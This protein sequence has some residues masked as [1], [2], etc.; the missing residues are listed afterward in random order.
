MRKNYISTITNTSTRKNHTNKH[1]KR[2]KNY[3][4]KRP[5]N[6]KLQ[7]NVP[8]GTYERKIEALNQE[9]MQ[10][11]IT[12]TENKTLDETMFE[13]FNMTSTDYLSWGIRAIT[14]SKALMGTYPTGALQRCPVTHQ[15]VFLNDAEM[16]SGVKPQI[17]AALASITSKTGGILTYSEKT[18]DVTRGMTSRYVPNE[19]MPP[20]AGGAAAWTEYS[21]TLTIIYFNKSILEPSEYQLAAVSEFGVR[22]TNILIYREI[23]R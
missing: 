21:D 14:F 3:K 4:R 23:Q 2:T 7:L 11:I 16:P 15:E 20:A 17:L 13:N 12:I 8:A 9:L 6:R 22:A 5:N 19:Q 18:T 10:D 1:N